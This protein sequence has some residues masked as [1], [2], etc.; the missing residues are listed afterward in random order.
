MSDPQL[1]TLALQV[2]RHLF[3]DVFEHGRGARN[4]A[5]GE[6][7]VLFGFFLRSDHFGF[8]FGA[9]RGVFLFGPLADLDQ[10]L[11]E[12]RNRITQREVAPVIGRAVFRRIIGGRVRTGAVGDPFDHGRAET[13]ARTFGG[14]GRGGIDGDEVVAI[15]PQGGNAATDA[16][17]GEGGGF[18]TGNRLERG[19]RPLVVDH[20]EDH[21]RA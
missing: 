2:L 20:V 7:A 8:Q 12:A 3:V 11:L 10:V 6:G 1:L 9:D 18:T 21:R 5:A 4:L 15:D 14:P 17:T 19:N 16:T 13:A